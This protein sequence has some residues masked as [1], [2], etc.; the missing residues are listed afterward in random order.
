MRILILCVAI[1][2]IALSPA[3]MA[4]ADQG[5]VAVVKSGFTAYHAHGSSA[6][7]KA[8][9]KGSPVEGTKPAMSQANTLNTVQDYYGN[10]TGYEITRVHQ[11]SKQGVMILAVADFQKGPL[12]CKFFLY[13]TKSQGWVLDYFQFNTYADRIWPD[14]MIYGQIGPG[15]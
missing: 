6:A 1:S 10:Y 2:G 11:L 9:L 14:D 7:L 12:F 8:W 5:A 3:A 13:Q 4:G 15:G